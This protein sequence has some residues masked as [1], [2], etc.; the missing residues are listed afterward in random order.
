MWGKSKFTTIA[1][2]T[3]QMLMILALFVL[4]ILSEY[5]AGVMQHLYYRK[6]HYLSTLYQNN[7][8]IFHV[9]GLSGGLVFICAVNKG[10]WNSNKA[11][12]MTC[13]VVMSLL[14]MAAYFSPW[15]KTLNVYAYL[16]IV[17]ECFVILETV[18]AVT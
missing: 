16:L 1:I 15:L 5:R 8:I 11:W 10:K 14:F 6:V 17:L 2:L 13:G 18:G 9:I 3:L 12:H 4:E 7:N